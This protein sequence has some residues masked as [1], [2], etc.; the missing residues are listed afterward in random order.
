MNHD[1][2]DWTRITEEA[3]RIVTCDV[4]LQNSAHGL[5]QLFW[6]GEEYKPVVWSSSPVTLPAR[7]YQNRPRGC[8]SGSKRNKTERH[9]WLG[10]DGALHK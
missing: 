7:I 6:V 5:P 4:C 3:T 1:G 2:V 9:S 10:P 8:W